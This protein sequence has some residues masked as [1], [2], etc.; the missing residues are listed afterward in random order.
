MGHALNGLCM[1][2]GLGKRNTHITFGFSLA[3]ALTIGIQNQ[4]V[5]FHYSSSMT[6]EL[7]GTKMLLKIINRCVHQ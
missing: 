3:V 2:A 1:F 7:L 4:T 6:G 5:C